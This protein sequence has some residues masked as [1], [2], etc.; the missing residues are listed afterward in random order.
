MPRLSI[1]LPVY[2][3]ERYLA[4]CLES[5]RAQTFGDIE[6]ICVN[7]GAT[8]RSP[9]L[10]DMAAAA[11]PRIVIVDKPNGGLSSAR[12]AGLA[13]A[14]GEYVLFVDSDDFLHNK[15]VATIV[16]TFEKTRAEIVTFGAFVHP[17]GHSTR[18]LRRTLRPRKITYDGFEPPLLFKE[19]SRPFV[20]RSAFTREF[21]VRE[22]LGFDE[23]VLF[24]EDQVFYFAAYPV[25]RRTALIPDQLYYYR[26]ARPDSLM[27]SRFENRKS[28]LREHHH[29]ARTILD[30]WRDHGWLQAH[31]PDMLG[32]VFEFLA[33]DAIVGPGRLGR[34]LRA[35]LAGLLAEYFPDGPWLR[36]AG[37]P[38]R[39]LYAVLAD[40]A[41]NGAVR[42]AALLAWQGTA[43]PVPTAL[44]LLARAGNAW[45]VLKVKGLA[46][47]VLPSPGRAQWERFRDLRDE[48]V[49]DA[50]RAEA[51]QMLQTE[52]LAARRPSD[53]PN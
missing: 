2:N 48:V 22:G 11:D 4:T 8:D 29:I 35:S 36:Q 53:E 44:G 12:N 21:L 51:M 49:D 45:P 10:L 20:W 34:E 7:D 14:T 19:S 3:V 26:A 16:K 41:S 28:M 50:R 5:V 43:Q 47:R 25:S 15:A 24:G 39:A 42:R 38:A 46:W 6:I 18:W 1:V 33:G 17:T 52:W 27:A 23:G 31:R 13:V 40:T 37:P 30:H 32:W 9:I